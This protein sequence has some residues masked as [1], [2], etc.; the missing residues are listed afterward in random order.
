MYIPFSSETT[1]ELR[2]TVKLIASDS[3]YK[4][5][6]RTD[7]EGENGAAIACTYETVGMYDGQKPEADNAGQISPYDGMLRN[8]FGI[9]DPALH[10][11]DLGV[12]RSQEVCSK[13]RDGRPEF[14]I[15]HTVSMA[16]RRD[17]SPDEALFFLEVDDSFVLASPTDLIVLNS[18]LNNAHLTSDHDDE[19]TIN[20]VL[21]TYR[22]VFEGGE[23]HD[24]VWRQRLKGIVGILRPTF[25]FELDA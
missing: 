12:Y 20:D 6:S 19:T 2:N 10:V 5:S 3:I 24:A 15:N 21:G 22:L 14:T 4:T 7:T 11:T 9:E 17:D 18:D 23:E 1:A 8:I 25:E 16:F 13:N